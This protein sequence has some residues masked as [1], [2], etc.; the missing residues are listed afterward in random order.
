MT[1]EAAENDGVLHVDDP[2]AAASSPASVLG[3]L[4]MEPRRV[5][6]LLDS[7]FSYA[8]V[9]NPILEET[10]T[11]KMVSTT[12]MNG[13]DWSAES[14]LSLLI[15]ALGSIATPFGPSHETMPGTL[16]HANAQ[17]FFQAAQKRLGILLS[18]DDII[19]AQ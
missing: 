10:A 18:S 13:I 3:A 2:T 6:D 4:D 1:R 19:A 11:R 12:I 16:A 5:N 15:F 9:K 7:F 14:C 17:S 8:H